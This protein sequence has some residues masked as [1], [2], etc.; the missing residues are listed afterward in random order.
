MVLLGQQALDARL[1]RPNVNQ[2]AGGLRQLYRRATDTGWL[3]YLPDNLISRILPPGEG[4]PY[5]GA[6]WGKNTGR[7]R[8]VR[9]WRPHRPVSGRNPDTL[10]PRLQN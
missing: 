4:S 1:G 7:R 2:S 8:L 3:F 5:F 10:H 6:M 9:F